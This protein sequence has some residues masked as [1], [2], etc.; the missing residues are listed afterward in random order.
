[1]NNNVMDIFNFVPNT[2]E[3]HI[4]KVTDEFRPSPKGTKSGV[5]EAV[6]RFLPN[7]DDPANKSVIRKNVVFLTNPIT[8]ESKLVDCPSTV[9][10]PDPIVNT[11][12]TLRKSASAVKQ[13]QSKMFSR[14]QRY[15]S[16]VQVLKCTTNPD[17]E[18]K[19]LVWNYGMKIYQKLQNEMAPAIGDPRNPF[20]VLNGR[21]FLVKVKEIGGFSNYD[22]CQFVDVDKSV[23]AFRIETSKGFVPVTAEFISSEKGRNAV[24]TYLKEHT[25]DLTPY[26]YHEWDEETEQFVSQVIKM[27]TDP[28]Y[29]PNAAQ[30]TFTAQ[31]SV[32]KPTIGN[33]VPSAPVQQP[34]ASA[35]AGASIDLDSL[36]IGNISDVMNQES[37]SAS[38]QEDTAVPNL[39]D[40]LSEIL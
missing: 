35:P 19:I 10:K 5:Y 4:N 6:V 9:G 7:P 30:P 29:V 18:N 12:F 26:E 21:A 27:Y 13:E 24:V 34:Q 38:A 31:T 36:G 20:D 1:M 11:F 23:S 39:D 22:D 37:S 8:N 40:I 17:I 32:A 16:L 15:A 25:P 33:V 2:Q 3:D 28:S 14:R